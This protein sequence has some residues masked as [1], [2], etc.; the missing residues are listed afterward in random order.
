MNQ[1]GS[2]DPNCAKPQCGRE[3]HAL[4]LSRN[5]LLSSPRLN[6]AQA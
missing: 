1:S 2:N 3:M 6:V 5:V 4:L